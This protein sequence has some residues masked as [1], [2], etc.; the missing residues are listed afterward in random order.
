M[1]VRSYFCRLEF[2]VGER[3]EKFVHV[4]SSCTLHPILDGSLD[5]FNWCSDMSGH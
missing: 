4:H 1:M 2:T 3:T 5:G